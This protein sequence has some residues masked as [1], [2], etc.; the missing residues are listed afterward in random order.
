MQGEVRI[1]T[2]KNKINIKGGS[3]LKF[4]PVVRSRHGLGVGG[5]KK[6]KTVSKLMG[7]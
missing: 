7:E 2:L 3:G 1:P 6:T 5:M 4:Y